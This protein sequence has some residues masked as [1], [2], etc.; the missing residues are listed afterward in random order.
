MASG[1]LLYPPFQANHSRYTFFLEM[2]NVGWFTMGGLRPGDGPVV[3]SCWGGN[4][5]STASVQAQEAISVMQPSWLPS[6]EFEAKVQ[7]KPASEI[8]PTYSHLQ[9]PMLD[10]GSSAIC[11]LR[12]LTPGKPPSLA[13][14]TQTGRGPTCAAGGGGGGGGGGAANH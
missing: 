14:R 2:A 4:S 8:G 7:S 6:G 5:M 9:L 11:E 10:S 1:G 13:R 12:T 3:A